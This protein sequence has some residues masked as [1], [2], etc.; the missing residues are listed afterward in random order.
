MHHAPQRSHL[1]HHHRRQ[2]AHG[3]RLHGQS[4][5]ARLPPAD[6][7]HHSCIDRHQSSHRRRLPQ[8]DDRLHPQV[9]SRPCPQSEERHLVA[10]PCHVHE[11]HHRRRRRRRCT[12][13]SRRH[14]ASS[15]PHRPR[16]RHPVHPRPHRFPPR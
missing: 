8:P 12:E 10:R 14:T 15:Q 16:A 1:R 6:A 3:G 2:A 13:H 9:L 7:P 4:R 5:R 11:M